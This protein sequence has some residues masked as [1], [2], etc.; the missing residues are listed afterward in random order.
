M[1]TISRG[2]RSITVEGHAGQAPIGH[3]I[4]CAGVTALV[5]ALGATIEANRDKWISR[6]LTVDSG[7]ARVSVSPKP[8]NTAY[9]DAIFDTI[10]C[11][12]EQIAVLYPDF[13]KYF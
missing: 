2:D 5:G 13:V 11:G 3:D 9:C 8:E 4:V 1:I 7:I 6:E 12:F 10:A